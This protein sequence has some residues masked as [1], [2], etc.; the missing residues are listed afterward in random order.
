MTQQ[1]IA[2]AIGLCIPGD[3]TI[4]RGTIFFEDG[5]RIYYSDVTR[6]ETLRNWL[7]HEVLGVALLPVR[8]Y[9]SI[10]EIMGGL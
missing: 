7:Y 8:T 4:L 10:Y 1:D 2:D 6:P 5:F 9:P 3:V